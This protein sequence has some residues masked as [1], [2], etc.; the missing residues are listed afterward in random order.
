[1]FHR[2]DIFNRSEEKDLLRMRNNAVIT[3]GE[4]IFDLISKTGCSVTSLQKVR[5]RAL[6]LER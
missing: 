2:E 5:I 1:M 3:A 4:G 6:A